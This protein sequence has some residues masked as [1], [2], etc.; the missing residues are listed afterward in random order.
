MFTDDSPRFAYLRRHPFILL[1]LVLH[2]VPLVALYHLG[3]DPGEKKDL[4]SA[5]PARVRELKAVMRR[6]HREVHEK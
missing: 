3:D 1:S 6:L 2:A 4:S 5:M